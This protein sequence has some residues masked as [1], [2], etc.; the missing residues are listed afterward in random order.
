MA[1]RGEVVGQFPPPDAIA[2][3]G[4]AINLDIIGLIPD[5]DSNLT[6]ISQ[7]ANSPTLLRLV[8]NMD[9]YLN[10]AVDLEQFYDFVWNVNTAVGFGLDIWG[11]IVD[12][13]RLLQIPSNNKKFGFRDGFFPLDVTPFNNAPFNTRGGNA[14]QAYLLPD[15]AY[16]VLILTKALANIVAT[17]APA[18]NQLLR[19][20]FP[21]RGECFVVDLG[22]MA[23]Q[24]TFGFAL[25]T[26]EYAILAQS[27][28]LPHPA[29]VKV[30][31]VTLASATTFGFSEAGPPA[32][33]F[34]QGTFYT[35]AE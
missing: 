2:T 11:R 34:D 15:D 8:D 18:L 29:G 30:S 32:Q 12:V 31:I 1:E 5:F 13:P 23:M 17:T 6:V 35:V 10:T 3:Y 19:N 7:Y 4:S 33:P 16:R 26:V 24:F 22:N 14:S 9:Q 27:G 20:L 28:A 25:S 21:G